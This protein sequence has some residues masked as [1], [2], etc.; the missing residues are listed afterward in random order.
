MSEK[1][2]IT[3]VNGKYQATM[4]DM[5]VVGNSI[6]E[7]MSLLENPPV[8]KNDDPAFVPAVDLDEINFEVDA[9][10][11]LGKT[12]RAMKA[13]Y[14]L[15]SEF[16][17]L[18]PPKKDLWK[19]K[20]EDAELT[21][22]RLEAMRLN[23]R[24][25]EIFE[26][27]VQ[28]GE[29]NDLGTALNILLVT[30]EASKGAVTNV[31][32]NAYSSGYSSGRNSA[33]YDEDDCED[34]DYDCDYDCCENESSFE[35]E[36]YF[37]DECDCDYE[38]DYECSDCQAAAESEECECCDCKTVAESDDCDCCGDDEGEY[39]EESF[40]GQSEKDPDLSVDHKEDYWCHYYECEIHTR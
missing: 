33:L 19:G 20:S 11:D 36:E 40:E 13:A 14:Q 26:E 5:T 37:G 16:G 32:E 9:D 8:A 15:Y 10:S 7:V 4:D 31:K 35:S 23:P 28:I 1:V 39:P 22:A 18:L 2:K 6:G 17:S 12:A 25:Q 24:L 27:N 38:V 29:V 30:V 3:A 21:P 34:C